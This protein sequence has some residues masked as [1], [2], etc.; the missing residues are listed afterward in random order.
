[1]HVDDARR[2]QAINP[3]FDCIRGHRHRG[4]CCPLNTR[5]NAKGF[6]AEQPRLIRRSALFIRVIRVFRGLK[7]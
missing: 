1:M 5:I 7:L 2:M 6:E 3:F 4:F